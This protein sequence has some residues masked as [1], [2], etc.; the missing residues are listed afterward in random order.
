MFQPRA[1]IQLCFLFFN[2]DDYGEIWSIF[3]PPGKKEKQKRL[4]LKI[5]YKDL[6]FI[7]LLGDD[8]NVN[9]DYDY[10]LNVRMRP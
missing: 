6:Y 5:E 10:M 2:G 4:T 8:N 9:V 7:L 3:V 1:T